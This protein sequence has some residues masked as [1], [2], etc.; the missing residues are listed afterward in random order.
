MDSLHF[1]PQYCGDEPGD[2]DTDARHCTAAEYCRAFVQFAKDSFGP[3]YISALTLME[4]D[5]GEKL[6]RMVYELIRLGVVQQQEGDSQSDFE[7]LFDLRQ[8]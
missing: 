8:V 6:G 4:L 7:G 2:V 5:T 1:A 3:D